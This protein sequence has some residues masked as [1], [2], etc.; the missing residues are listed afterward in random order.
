MVILRPSTT[1]FEGMT[2]VRC[3]RA[4]APRCPSKRVLM[5]GD[6]EVLARGLRKCYS[7]TPDVMGYIHQVWHDVSKYHIC[8][9][10][11]HIIGMR[12]TYTRRSLR[13]PLPLKRTTHM[14]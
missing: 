3:T 1:V 14:H 9:R 6:N 11:A 12:A 5:E 2:A 7:P 10:P 4:F 13:T 8:L